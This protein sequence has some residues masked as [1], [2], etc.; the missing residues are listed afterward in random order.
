MLRA[1][2]VVAFVG[3]ADLERAVPFYRDVLGLHLRS[4]DGFAAA[5][6]AHG[7]P[8]RVTLVPQYAAMGHT[9]LGCDTQ[10]FGLMEV[11]ARIEADARGAE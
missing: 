5:F 10:H 3:A 1:E 9:V 11:L 7:T 6:D 4:Q 8:L 2:Q